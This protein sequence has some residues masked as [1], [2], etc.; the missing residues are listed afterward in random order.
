MGAFSHLPWPGK[1]EQILISPA[2]PGPF[3]GPGPGLVPR[4]RRK[5]R[6]AIMLEGHY[7]SN[8]RPCDGHVGSGLYCAWNSKPWLKRFKSSS[9][10][11][12][13]FP[14]PSESVARMLLQG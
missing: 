5:K 3:H 9:W 11:W 1:G 8:K 10:S 4:P 12:W 6:A 2:P 14:N 13:K 7:S